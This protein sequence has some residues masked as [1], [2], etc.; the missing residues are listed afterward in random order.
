MQVNGAV[1][2]STKASSI[3]QREQ[4]KVSA[5]E[6]AALAAQAVAKTV[7]KEVQ[8]LAAHVATL[9]KQSSS[10]TQH[11]STLQLDSQLQGP[12][13]PQDSLGSEETT[14]SLDVTKKVTTSGAASPT[15]LSLPSPRNVVLS[16][17]QLQT[18]A[19]PRSQPMLTSVCPSRMRRNPSP[20]QVNTRADSTWNVPTIPC[21]QAQAHRP[22]PGPVQIITGL[23]SILNPS[24]N[25]TIPASTAPSLYITAPSRGS[26]FFDRQGGD[27]VCKHSDVA[28]QFV[29]TSKTKELE[30]GN[31]VVHQQGEFPKSKLNYDV[32]SAHNDPALLKRGNSQTGSHDK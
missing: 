19:V 2:S 20:K 8:A 7:Q 10:L 5:A 12:R 21:L 32:V 18:D 17:N 14:T 23:Q 3:A 4:S 24:V 28:K 30:G 29:T 1:Q 6:T 15:S 9:Q 13:T 22:R 16:K 25:Q 26:Q 11:V 27:P 31:T